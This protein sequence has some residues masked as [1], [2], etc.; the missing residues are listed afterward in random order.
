[1]PPTHPARRGQVQPAL[2]VALGVVAIV[3]IVAAVLFSRPSA[4]T[5][6]TASD[7]PSAT[8]VATPIA[9]PTDVPTP[10]ATPTPSPTPTPAPSTGLGSIKLRNA[11]NHDVVLQVHDQTE[12]LTGAVSGEPG[13]GMSVR[14]HDAL[15][16]NANHH[17]ILVT[18]VGLPQDDTLDL[19]VAIV[20]GQLHVT[21]VQAGPVANSDAMG[22]DRIVALTFDR[23]IKAD[24][25][26]VEILDR[27]ID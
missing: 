5:G 11:T 8:P 20:D 26:F 2:A 16:K 14:W 25:V 6:P 15:V 23:A 21:I 12:T 3:G 22:E 24:D 9:T 10:V 19:G 4:P 17:T 7:R 1:M 27:T 18:W 13:D